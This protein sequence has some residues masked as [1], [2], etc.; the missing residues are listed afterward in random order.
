MSL[1]D[2]SGGDPP[3]S[4]IKIF[5]PRRGLPSGRAVVGALLVTVA[6]VGAFVMARSNDGIPDTSYLVAVRSVEAGTQITSEDIALTPMIL[7]LETAANALSS[8]IGVDGATATSDLAAGDLIR[9]RDLISAP[10]VDGVAMGAIHEL[11]LPVDRNRIA[12]RVTPGDRVT[13]LTT[14]S[15]GDTTATVVAAEDTMVLQWSGDGVVSG[16]GVLTLAMDDADTAM[17]L[18]H[19][20]RQGSVTVVRTTRAVDDPYPWYMSTEDLLPAASGNRSSA[21]ISVWQPDDGRG[22]AEE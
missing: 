19:L 7:P 12:S 6:A 17:S 10:D 14:L 8:A 9:E 21:P 2:K 15:H 13:V 5:S 1:T 20:A 16:S 18:A 3:E 4:K 22:G 11:A